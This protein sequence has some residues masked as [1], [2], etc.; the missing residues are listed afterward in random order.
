MSRRYAIVGAQ[1]PVCNVRREP[2]MGRMRILKC[3]WVRAFLERCALYSTGCTFCFAA[4]ESCVEVRTRWAL[5]I[6]TSQWVRIKF[7]AFAN[8][9]VLVSSFGNVRNRE[10]TKS[11]TP[12]T[13]GIVAHALQ[14]CVNLAHLSHLQMNTH[15]TDSVTP[16]LP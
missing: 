9:C 11:F 5:G 6:K 10:T 2:S 16:K 13:R 15:S 1:W 3:K 12:T 4:I 14:S 7:L 8:R